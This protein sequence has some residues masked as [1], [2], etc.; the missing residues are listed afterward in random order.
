M[1]SLARNIALCSTLV[2]VLVGLGAAPVF[3]QGATSG[4]L[5][6]TVTAAEDGTGLPGAL[7]EAVHQ[8]TG[9][10]YNAVTRVDGRWAV[11]NARVGGPYTISVDMDGFQPAE[12]GDVFVSL[13]EATEVDVELRLATVSE[14]LTVTA[15]ID[16]L[17]N[18]NRTGATTNVGQQLI[19]DLPNIE[20]GFQDLARVSPYFST[21]G[22][23]AGDEQTVIS[24]AGRNNRYNN[25]QIDGAVNNDLFGLAATG[26]PGGQAETQPITS[27]RSRRSQLLVSPY[28]VRQGGFTGGGINAITRS[29]TNDSR[30]RSTTTPGTRDW[31]GDGPFDQRDQRVQR[32]RSTASASAARSSATSCSSSSPPSVPSARGRPASRP[33]AA[34]ARRSTIRP[35]P[36]SS[37]T[38]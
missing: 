38:S 10:R 13:S 1:S 31:V 26:T 24:V 11:E 5:F 21:F 27:T 4:T 33:T 6:G 29:G 23:G 22:G 37:G 16:P 8:P 7:V 19:E 35:R 20:R 32:G 36:P 17:I 15:E 30:A 25:I 3:G 9:T 2:A 12:V 28:D 34:A 18:P 14:E